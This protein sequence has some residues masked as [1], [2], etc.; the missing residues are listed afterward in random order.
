MQLRWLSELRRKTKHFLTQLP[1]PRTTMRTWVAKAEHLEKRRD[2]RFVVTSLSTA[3]WLAQALYEEHYCD[4][5]D[6]ENRI[7]RTTDAIQR[8]H[9]LN[10]PASA[11]V[12]GR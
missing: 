8:P 7:K 3:A 2:P 9:Q 4:R 12:A 5:G 11:G 1:S 10:W 6:M